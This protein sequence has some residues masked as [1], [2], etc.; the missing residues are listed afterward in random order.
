MIAHTPDKVTI[1]RLAQG[2]HVIVERDP[3]FDERAFVNE[4]GLLRDL[5]SL[6]GGEIIFSENENEEVDEVV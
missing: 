4:R 1:R 2:F 5:F 3:E 6:F